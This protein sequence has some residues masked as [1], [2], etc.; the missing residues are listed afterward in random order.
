MATPDSRWNSHPKQKNTHTVEATAVRIVG[1]PEGLTTRALPRRVST[2]HCC[3]NTLNGA[4][5]VATLA[6]SPTEGQVS[7]GYKVRC[8][9]NFMWNGPAD[10]DTAVERSAA[11]LCF[12]TAGCTHRSAPTHT[13]D[14][15]ES[16][17]MEVRVN[18]GGVLQA[19][20]A[21]DSTQKV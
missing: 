9:W 12:Q 3:Q 18:V 17:P 4:G 21:T 19:A 6:Y 10:H 14:R 13:H 7:P 20:N 5:R 2:R 16:K 1:A 11:D 8:W 15:I